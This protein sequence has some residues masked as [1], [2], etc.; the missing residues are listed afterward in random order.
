MSL[1]RTQFKD[2]WARRRALGVATASLLFLI[3]PLAAA[4][5]DFVRTGFY[6]GDGAPTFTVTGLDFQPSVVIIKASTNRRAIIKTQDM[7]D[8]QSKKL[9]DNRALEPDRILTLDGNGF[10]VGTNDEVN[11][12]GEDF[13]WI[14]MKS[15]VGTVEVGSYVGNGNS[16][17]GVP[18]PGMLA[19]AALV[20]PG[21]ADS[22]VY[23]TTDMNFWEAYSLDGAGAQPNSIGWFDFDVMNV[24][25]SH[26]VNEW[27]KTYYFVAWNGTFRPD[28]PKKKLGS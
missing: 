15:E 4:A 10:T 21:G 12:L 14:A 16:V 19:D 11:R 2:I 28:R 23:R 6:T 20:I 27:G 24:G 18:V 1:G 9:D 17:R 8:G 26:T 5:Q 7:P 3:F 22:P 13:Y 25:N